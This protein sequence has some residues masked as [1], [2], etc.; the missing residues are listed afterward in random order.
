MLGVHPCG[1]MCQNGLPFKDELHPWC[2]DTAF[3]LSS[4]ALRDTVGSDAAGTLGAGVSPR[5]CSG[6]MGVGTR[7]GS[8]ASRGGSI[9]NV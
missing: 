5:A 2:V 3:C 7:S 9:F 6:F 4:H 8:A 1:G